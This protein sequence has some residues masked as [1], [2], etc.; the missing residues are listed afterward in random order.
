MALSFIKKDSIK[1]GVVIGFV[2]PFIVLAIHYYTKTKVGWTWAD[3]THFLKTEK[4]FLTG[5]STIALI[6]NG[7]LFGILIQFK[8]F[9]TAK[10]VFIPTVLLSI[11]VL[12]FKLF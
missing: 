10:G 7:L 3:Y 8:R 11:S 4:T 1:L 9:E 6:A 5:V 12:L 2:L